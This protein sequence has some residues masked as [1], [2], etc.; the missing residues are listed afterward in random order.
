[1]N[2]LADELKMDPLQLRILNDAEKDEDKKMPFS[3]RHFRECFEVGAKKFGWEHRTQRSA[4]CGA[5]E[6]S[7]AGDWPAQAG[8]RWPSLHSH[9]RIPRQRPRIRP[10]WD[11]GHRH[12]HIHDFR[13]GRARED[14]HPT[15]SHR[16]G[17]R[18]QR[19][20]RRPHVRRLDGDWI[21]AER[22]ARRRGSHQESAQVATA[23]PARRI[24][25]QARNLAF[26][27]GR[28]HK[29]DQRRQTEPN[30]PTCCAWPASTD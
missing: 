13:A 9:R 10:L 1:M 8:S 30:L 15:R 14:R 25:K 22:H 16:R 18:R 27:E 4:R 17:D 21:R 3:S 11:A 5:T 24:T 28:I 2:E 29:K 19:A 12:W 26:T 23:H 7:W 20:A 6:R